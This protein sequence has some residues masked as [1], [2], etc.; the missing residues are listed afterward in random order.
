MGEVY[1]KLSTLMFYINDFYKTLGKLYTDVL[2]CV[3]IYSII[4]WRGWAVKN[5]LKVAK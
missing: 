4:Q 2:N 5:W 1:Y 3:A